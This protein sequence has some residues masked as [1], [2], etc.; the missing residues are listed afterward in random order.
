MNTG[1]SGS[2]S[3]MISADSQSTTATHAITMNGTTDAS[4][5]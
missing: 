1:T 4:T 3:N 5:T 2:V